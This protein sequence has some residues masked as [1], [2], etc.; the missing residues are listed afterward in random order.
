MGRQKKVKEK[1]VFMPIAKYQELGE[2]LQNISIPVK[3]AGQIYKV[4]EF[5]QKNVSELEK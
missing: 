3:F 1:G 2:Q 5:I 4:L